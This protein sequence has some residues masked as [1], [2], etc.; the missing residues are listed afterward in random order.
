M[1][2]QQEGAVLSTLKHPNIVEVYGTFLEEH[3]SSIIMELLE[4]G[5]LWQVLAAE[6]LPLGRT[7]ALMLQVCSALA[8]AHGHG[9][10]HRDVK[11]SNIMVAENDHVKVTDFGIARVLGAGAAL[12]TMTGTTMGTPFYM[13]PEQIMARPVDARSDV[14]SV[15]VVLYE[16]VTGQRPFEGDDPISVAFKHVNSNPQPPNEIAG[17]VPADW[18]AIIL[19]CLAKDPSDRYASA[20]AL[21]E[22]VAAA[23]GDIV[24]LP[25]SVPSDVPGPEPEILTATVVHANADAGPAGVDEGVESPPDSPSAAVRPSSEPPA[26]V[27]PVDSGTTPPATAAQASPPSE[28][29]A[30]TPPPAVPV[31]VNE[32]APEPE[33]GVQEESPP[34]DRPQEKRSSSRMKVVVAVAIAVVV[35]VAGILAIKGLSGK[36]STS[37]AASTRTPGNRPTA[38]PG[39]SGGVIRQWGTAGSKPGQF[40]QPTGATLDAHG[41]V[42]IADSGNNRIQEFTAAGAFL[43]AWGQSGA[44]ANR[45][46]SPRGVALDKQG[47][48]YVADTGN[49]RIVKFGPSGGLLSAWG[50]AGSGKGEFQGPT[51]LTLVHGDIYVA[52][53]GNNRIQVLS[54]SGAFADCWGQQSMCVGAQFSHPAAVAVDKLSDLFVAEAGADRIQEMTLGG[55]QV[56]TW[57]STGAGPGQLQG[58]E[59][60]T[61]DARSNVYVADTGND[62]IEEFDSSG[63]FVSQWGHSGAAPGQFNGLTSVRADRQGSLYVVDTG[64]NRVQVL[65]VGRRPSG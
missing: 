40:H 62:R 57:G 10:I 8:Y 43:R 15:G 51:A 12:R 16:M 45:L 61:L 65:S 42:Y 53:T 32:D 54:P 56:N 14:Y 1:R 63:K 4:G 24:E 25:S 46:N 2:F 49:N 11:P 29:T 48:L 50:R 47:N 41:N 6:R 13:S 19:K 31:P 21:Q 18:E 38:R 26:T 37:P 22:A 55:D 60:I 34:V 35:L 52:D 44:A 7:K 5:S 64:N 30:S 28:I 33:A 36:N 39:A 58:P 20:A 27:A 23:S 17:D 59:G 9:I 3:T